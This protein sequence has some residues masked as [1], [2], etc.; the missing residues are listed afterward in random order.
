MVPCVSYSFISTP[1]CSSWTSWQCTVVANC[2]NLCLQTWHADIFVFF[3]FE[4]MGSNCAP[5]IAWDD[6]PLWPQIGWWT[7][8]AA[9]ATRSAK[10]SALRRKHNIMMYWYSPIRDFPSFSFLLWCRTSAHRC[11]KTQWTRFWFLSSRY[12]SGGKPVLLQTR[13]FAFSFSFNP[14]QCFPL[15]SSCSLAL[16]AP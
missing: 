1:V 8:R 15:L 11:N 4:A 9:N 10:V 5:T 12:C 13:T 2:S 14:H 3:L 16:Q 7:R 6:I